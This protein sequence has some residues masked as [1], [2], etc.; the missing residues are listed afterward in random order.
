MG[1]PGGAGVTVAVVDTGIAYANRGRFLRSPDFSQYRFV[2]GYDFVGND[3]YPNDDNGHGTH[4]AGTI[5]EGTGQRRR[6]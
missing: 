4:V 5:A 2:K 6:R 3:R 1:R